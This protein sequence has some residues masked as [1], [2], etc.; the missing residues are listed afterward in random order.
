MEITSTSQKMA[1][2]D[3]GTDGVIFQDLLGQMQAV[4]APLTTDPR[5]GFECAVGVASGLHVLANLLHA[6]ESY[7]LELRAR[8]AVAIFAA[9]DYQMKGVEY[10]DNSKWPI[11]WEDSIQGVLG[12]MERYQGMQTE[13]SVNTRDWVASKAPPRQITLRISIVTVCDY[14][15]SVTPLS[16]LSRINKQHYADLHGYDFVYYEKSPFFSD[17]FQ[18]Q[19]YDK[20]KRPPA[21]GKIDAV[22]NAMISPDS[23]DW[24][25]WMDCD[26]FFE[27]MNVDLEDVIARSGVPTLRTRDHVSKWAEKI[28]KWK[29][30]SFSEHVWEE[31]NNFVTG[32]VPEDSSDDTAADVIASEDGL[33]LNTGIFFARNSVRNFLFFQKI[34]QFTFSNNPAMFHTWWEQTG[35]MFLISIPPLFESPMNVSNGG[36]TSNVMYVNQRILNVYPPLIS[37][38]LRTHVGYS[39]GDFIVSFSGCKTFTSQS[40]CNNLFFQY[41]NKVLPGKVPTDLLKFFH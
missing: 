10:I 28:Q 29:P 34:R 17:F 14:D 37:S 38:M 19:I 39:E 21:W 31:Y 13:P 24:I 27:D 6:T 35:M 40:V 7:V 20:E 41:F 30:G 22:L 9:Y 32:L 1:G 11:R 23:S 36:I 25:M 4:M 12:A 15:Q 33:M 16:I 8:Q 18:T 5:I 2:T 3:G 26:S